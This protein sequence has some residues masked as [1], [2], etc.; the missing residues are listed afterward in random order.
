MRLK[1]KLPVTYL[2]FTV[3]GRLSKGAFLLASLFYW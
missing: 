1:Q 2:L 3:N